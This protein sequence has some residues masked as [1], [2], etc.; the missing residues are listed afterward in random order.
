M[1]STSYLNLLQRKNK[2]VEEPKYFRS[3][4]NP[5]RKIEY[6]KIN[7]SNIRFLKKL[8]ITVPT[9]KYNDWIQHTLKTESL[10]ANITTK[11]KQKRYIASKMIRTSS[12]LS[13]TTK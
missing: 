1:Y 10:K 8:E 7:D 6:Q 12:F 13:S 4:S 9:Y 5:K 2:Y 3:L 11:S